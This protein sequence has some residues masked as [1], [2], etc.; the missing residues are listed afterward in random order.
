MAGGDRRAMPSIHL[1]REQA[2]LA[3]LNPVRETDECLTHVAAIHHPVAGVGR[4]FVKHYLEGGRL[5]R[6]PV[7]EICGYLLAAEAG[8]PVADRALLLVLPADRLREMHPGR[9]M[10]AGAANVL[11]WATADVGGLALPPNSELSDNQLRAAPIAAP[12]IAFDSWLV[13]RDRSAGNLARRR[14][15][16]IVVLDH[17]HLG[18]SVFWDAEMLP[19]DDES[20]HPFLALWPAGQIPDE[21]NQ[22]IIV[23]AEGHTSCFERALPELN[24]WMEPLL[25][26]AR[27]RI[28]LLRFLQERAIS[29]PAR[30]KRVLQMLA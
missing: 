17:G 1:L 13:V 6:G 7:N 2:Y 22:R 23:A 8:L 20:R 5:S 12:L 29:S 9:A 11:A 24:R 30:M 14:N 4:Y 21:V 18:G 26:D 19:T 28:A 3:A 15:G 27:D 10:T 16:Q 25:A